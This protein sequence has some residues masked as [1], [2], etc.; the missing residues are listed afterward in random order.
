MKPF[1]PLTTSDQL[2]NHL[3]EEILNGELV[4]TMPGINHLVKSMGI[5]SVAVTK[6]LKQLE[7]ENLIISQ[8]RRRK[9]LISKEI[10]PSS[11]SLRVAFLHYDKHNE[12]R[13]D[14]ILARQVLIDAGHKTITAPKT[15]QDLGMNTDRI[16]RMAESIDVDAWIIFAASAETLEW[17]ANFRLPA[18]AIY[19]R[20]KRQ[21]MPGIGISKQHTTEKVINRLAELGHSRIVLMIRE[22]RRKPN[23]GSVELTF[24]KLLESHGIKTSSYNIPDWKE[25]SEGLQECLEN[26]LLH[27]PPTAM[28]VGDPVLF[29]AIQIHLA[30]RGLKSP[31]HI[32]LFCDDYAESFEWVLP[33]I[34]HIRWDHR[35]ILRRVLQW[36]KNVTLGKEDLKHTL[37]IAKLVDNGSIGPV[38]RPR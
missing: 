27:T 4:G 18:L 30:N 5:N 14:S 12:L 6:A 24:L 23:L 31:E 10:K 29:H 9:R 11:K 34:S 21:N 33:S 17:F 32:S 19:G 16:A 20:F 13:H 22:E 25:S 36:T 7:R 35:P 3:R 1:R 2:A 15:M 28:I 26:L 38:P 37:T 8:G